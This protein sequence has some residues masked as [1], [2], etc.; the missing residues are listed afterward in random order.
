MQRAAAR[1]SFF[2]FA[3]LRRMIALYLIMTGI[4][5]LSGEGWNVLPYYAMVGIL[6]LLF[7][8]VP[9]KFLPL[10]SILLFLLPWTRNAIVNIKAELKTRALY[11]GNLYVDTTALDKLT[12][13]YE[14]NAGR[15]TVITREGTALFGQGANARIRLYA[16]SDTGFAL[17]NRQVNQYF[18]KDST[19]KIA[20][21]ILCNNNGEEYYSANKTNKTTAEGFNKLEQQKSGNVQRPSYS[22]F[23]NNNAVNIRNRIKN[24][25]WQNFIWLNNYKIGYI[26]VLFLLGLYA[27]KRKIFSNIAASRELLFKVFKWGM[28]LG[29]TGIVI[30]FGFEAWNFYNNIKGESYSL[31]TITFIHLLWDI[32]RIIM[33]LAYI[34]GLALLLEKTV[35]KKRLSFFA[36]V[37]RMGFTNYILHLF[38]YTIVFDKV[39]WFLGLGGKIGCFY[40]IL[41]TIPVYIILY[42]LSRWWL[43]HFKYGPFEWLWRSLTYLKFQ[44]MRLKTITKTEEKE[45]GNI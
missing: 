9:V 38:A 27:G 28:L 24:W 36:P 6:L 39:S 19:G 29:G 13:V 16:L 37:G 3:F 21:F 4:V 40:R 34:A 35:W 43:S 33:A 2:G 5:I 42:L 1:N 22:T 8:K 41:I 12:G 25:S 45:I 32:G 44:P 30:S 23:V 26:L 31:W 10:V 7:W 20:K 17:E 15:W 11:K 14:N 18:I